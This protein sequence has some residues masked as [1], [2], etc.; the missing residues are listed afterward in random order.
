MM[1]SHKNLRYLTIPLLHFSTMRGRMSVPKELGGKLWFI[2]MH[3]FIAT[4]TFLLIKSNS[5]LCCIGFP[6]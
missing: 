5:N 2:S 1:D 3:S 6:G 4:I